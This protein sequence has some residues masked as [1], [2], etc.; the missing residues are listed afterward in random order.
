MKEEEEG[1]SLQ[2]EQERWYV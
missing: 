1:R 2:Y